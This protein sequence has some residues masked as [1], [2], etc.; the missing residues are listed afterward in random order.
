MSFNY[1]GEGPGFRVPQPLEDQTV[2]LPRA[3]ATAPAP[4]MAAPDALTVEHR[5]VL[6]EVD[7]LARQA[8]EQLTVWDGRASD[9]DPVAAAAM[10]QAI[11]LAKR[12]V[13]V[14]RPFHSGLV[15]E[16]A[17]TAVDDDREAY[18]IRGE[19]GSV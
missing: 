6:D 15:L 12:L 17:I 10:G 5:R 16:D 18:Q 19:T 3:R 14:V 11:A 8:R 2:E 13:E 7:S 9:S 1:A 4:I